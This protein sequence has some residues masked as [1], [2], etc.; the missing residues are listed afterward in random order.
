MPEMLG[1]DQRAEVRTLGCAFQELA[2]LD[3]ADAVARR[4]VELARD[5]IGLERAGFYRID[6]EALLMTGTW[7][8][9]LQ[10]RTVDEHH[11]MCE[12]GE[13]A[14]EAFR[15]AAIDG[16]PWTLVHNCPI[17]VHFGSETQVVGRSWLACTPIAS[18]Q[19]AIAM[20]FNDPGLSR[21]PMDESKQTLLAILCSFVGV[22]LELL[23]DSADGAPA[24]SSPAGPLVAAVVQALAETPSLSGAALAKQQGIS[25]SRLARVFKEEMGMSLVEH[26]NRLRL[27]RFFLLMRSG[28]LGLLPAALDAGFG[29]YAQFHRVF[30]AL[31]GSSPGAY[32]RRAEGNSV[33]LREGERL[34]TR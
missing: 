8:T 21:K 1:G 23:A 26:R 6:A 4:A 3:E 10:R 31:H 22:R 19:R 34:R 25:L 18:K 16:V 7:G 17:S 28:R 33:P 14:R 15:R 30:R 24:R 29:S 9:D 12:W 20:M 27:K 2:A 32:L 5:A 13:D 11:V